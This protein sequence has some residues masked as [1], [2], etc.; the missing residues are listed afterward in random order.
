MQVQIREYAPTI[1]IDSTDGCMCHLSKRCAEDKD[2]SVTTSK[3]SE[4]N[5]NFPFGPEGEY[6]E[7]P[8]C[9]Q[10][11]FKVNKETGAITTTES[12]IYSA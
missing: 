7:K 2:F 5:I 6:V 10:F 3:C 11:K 4:V 9:E 12:D 1:S 8:L